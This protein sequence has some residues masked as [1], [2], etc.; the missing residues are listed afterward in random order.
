MAPRRAWLTVL[1][2]LCAAGLMLAAA[3]LTGSA[4]L[5]PGAVLRGLSAPDSD[6]GAIVWQLRMPRALAAFAAGGLLALA[7][8]LL[9]ALLR[10]P[11][12]EPYLL[13]VSGGAAV[14]ALSL[15]LL[16][17]TSLGV[18]AG[19]AGG[20]LGSTALLL[21]LA[22]RDFSDPSAHGRTL[23]LGGVALAA[24][25]GAV[26]ALILTMA[27][28]AS[29]SGMLFWLMGDLNGVSEWAVAMAILCVA[30]AVVLPRAHALNALMRGDEV[31]FALG[32]DVPR[33][34]WLAFICAAL[35]AAAA[36]ATV[37][38]IGFV[39]LVA[40]H[41][42]RMLVGNDQRVLLPLATLGGGAMLVCADI[43]ARSIVAPVQLPTGAVMAL[44]GTPIFLHLLLRT[45]HG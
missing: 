13:G 19:A 38:T 37:G 34:R 40:P 2:A 39:G 26:V 9:Q 3:M 18:H 36:V 24:L 7:G 32:I 10:N 45:R 41:L 25:A 15:M 27:P 4:P 31:A 1:A 5:E 16:G 21:L 22:R 30:A 33:L 11:L 14:G 20:A 42:A 12:A 44:L 43:V 23:L 35:A 17:G 6:A 8:A 28:E 29:L